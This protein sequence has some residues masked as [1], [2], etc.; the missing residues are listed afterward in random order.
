M[1]THPGLESFHWYSERENTKKSLIVLTIVVPGSTVVEHLTHY[2]N[3]EG[4]NPAIC[5]GWEKE[6]E[7]V[8]MDRS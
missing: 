7:K 3:N 2:T 4:S 8:S 6:A 5:T 1:N